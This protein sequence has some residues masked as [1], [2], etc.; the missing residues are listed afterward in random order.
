VI[1][2]FNRGR[3]EMLKGGAL[4]VCGS[5]IG[6]AGVRRALAA[7]EPQAP[8]AELRYAQVK[9]EPGPVYAQA[10]ENHQLVMSLDEDSLLRPFRQRAGLPAPGPDL[11]GWYDT[12]A[13]A[14]GATFGQWMCALAR[15]HA[16]DGDEPTRAKV[17]RLVRGFAA[18]VDTDGKFYHNNRFP[19]YI[20]DKLAGGLIDAK[21]YANDD[22]A[23]ATL[24]RATRAAIPYLPPHAMPRNEHAQPGEDFSQHAWDESYTIPENQFFAARLTGDRIHL[25]LARR[26]LYDDFFLALARGD[27]VLPGKHAYSHVNGLNSA[28]QAYLALGQRAYFDAARQGFDFIDAQSFATGGWGPDEHF[29]TPGS[30]GLGAS[31]TGE[32]KSFET[33]CGAYA[34][35]KLTRYLL[36]I[37]RDSRYGDSM[38]RVLYNCALGAKPIQPDGNAFYYS[39]YTRSASKSFHPD[40]WPCCSGTLPMLAADYPISACFTDPRGIFVNLYIP[41]RIDWRQDTAACRLSITTEYPYDSAVAMSLQLSQPRNFALKLRIPAWATGASVTVNGKRTAAPVIPGT[42]ASIEREWRSGDRVELDLPLRRR[43]Q[44]VDAEH[45]NIV[46]LSSGP[47]VLMRILDDEPGTA[48]AL[49]RGVLQAAERVP[50]RE[51]S[52]TVSHT[53][54][55]IELRAFPDINAQRYSA[56]Q[57]VAG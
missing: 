55:K 13:F 47:L 15:Y 30:G 37:T 23:I 19:A 53:S 21:R 17:Q 5:V 3:R 2:D 4:L 50:G 42:F 35:F 26:F 44:A 38:E 7:V 43:L 52:W 16:A 8:L 51:R 18:T 45:P 1:S 6:A 48:A 10:R 36:R 32:H 25:A 40:R 33:P 31:L 12:Y 28:A 22:N 14:P 54:R 27:N 57:D 34:H 29:V 9:F 11:G 24:R 39:D 49:P 20:Y 41:G 46:A 56:Y